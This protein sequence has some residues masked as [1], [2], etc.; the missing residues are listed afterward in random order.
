MLLLVYS[1]GMNAVR[2][3]ERW[4]LG[5]LPESAAAEGVLKDA[6]A[7][8]AVSAVGSDGDDRGG[9]D[10]GDLALERRHLNYRRLFETMDR[11]GSRVGF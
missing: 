11:R 4:S 5:R 8:R 7:I 1:A 2:G 10:I 9:A 3:L 6:R